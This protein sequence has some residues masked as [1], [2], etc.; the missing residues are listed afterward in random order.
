MPP[1]ELIA[2]H[3]QSELVALARFD[4]GGF[5]VQVARIM[6]WKEICRLIGAYHYSISSDVQV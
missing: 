6:I 5:C 3:I 4:A 2:P 1:S